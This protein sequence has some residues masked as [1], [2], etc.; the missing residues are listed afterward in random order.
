MI[1]LIC[2]V[3]FKKLQKLLWI[4]FKKKKVTRKRKQPSQEASSAQEVIQKI[5]QEKKISCKINYDV[6]ND[7][8]TK[9]ATVKNTPE[10]SGIVWPA[11]SADVQPSI[12]RLRKA[13][14]S[15]DLKPEVR[16]GTSFI[17]A[18]TVS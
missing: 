10:K 8:N 3:C 11:S 1:G 18:L 5:I 7:L 4:Y 15:F 16:I 12:A 6:L 14:V 9:S 17:A 13:S 2:P